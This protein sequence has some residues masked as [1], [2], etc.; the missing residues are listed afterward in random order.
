MV[1][2]LKGGWLEPQKRRTIPQ[3]WP[4]RGRRRPL[5]SRC[6]EDA[7]SGGLTAG[8]TRSRQRGRWVRARRMKSIFNRLLN[9]FYQPILAGPRVKAKPLPQCAY[10][11]P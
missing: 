8:G 11:Q 1:W 9:A 3:K 7:E 4:W 10:A 5:A 6:R 2:R